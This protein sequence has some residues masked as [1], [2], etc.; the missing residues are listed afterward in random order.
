MSEDTAEVKTV[1]MEDINKS[2]EGVQDAVKE[3]TKTIGGLVAEQERLRK[4]GRF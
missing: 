3:L 4:S 2:L 1:T